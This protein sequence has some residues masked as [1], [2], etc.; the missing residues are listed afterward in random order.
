MDIFGYW[1]IPFCITAYYALIY[2]VLISEGCFSSFYMA[3][4]VATRGVIV[5]FAS[6]MLYLIIF[7]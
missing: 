6:W 4:Q 2:L 3:S 7:Y 5:S 1:L